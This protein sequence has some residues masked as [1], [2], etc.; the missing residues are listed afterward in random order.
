VVT[1]LLIFTLV[2]FANPQSENVD[3]SITEAC[4]AQLFQFKK[5]SDLS[6]DLSRVCQNAKV[7][8]S[9]LSVTGQTIFHLDFP[10][11]NGNKKRILVFSLIHGDELPAGDVSRFWVERLSSIENP[12]NEWRVIPVLNPDGV[13]AKSRL[14]ANGVDLNRNF[15]TR[16]WDD[17]AHALWKKLNQNPRRY[18]G[19]TASSEPETKCALKHI[20][21]FKPHFIVSIHTPLAVLDF[22]G[23]KLTKKPPY[24]YLPWKSLG[25]FPGSL[26]RYM[27]F[28][29]EV[30]VLTTEFLSKPP[31]TSE[32]LHQLQDVI[33]SLVTWL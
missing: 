8:E 17:Q 2:T 12:R 25:H 5:Y 22:D 13:K 11:R 26:G 16:D 20:E 15:P 27:W 3:P 19:A 7:L 14:N 6:V 1:S 23:P 10:S 24:H 28:E 18:P 30:P 9:C 21:D 31:A 33:G 4:Y 29:R 32:P